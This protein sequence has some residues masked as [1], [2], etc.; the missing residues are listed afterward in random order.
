MS[1]GASPPASAAPVSADTPALS[2]EVPSTTAQEQPAT[3]G[4]SDGDAAVSGDEVAKEVAADEATAHDTDADKQTK[5]GDAPKEGSEPAAE[6]TDV[7]MKDAEKPEESVSVADADA[8]ADG[9]AEPAEGTPASA[10][11][12]KGRRKSVGVPEHKNKKLSKKASVAKITHIDAK[13][14]DYFLARLKG[15]PPWPCIICS[16]DMIPITLNKSRPMSAARADG[17]Y[18]PNYEDGAPKAKDR[19]FPIMYLA[20]NEFGWHVNTELTDV[21]LDTV[22]EMAVAKKKGLKEA[23]QIAAEQ[24][25]LDF[26][27]QMLIAHEESRQAEIAEKAAAK[28]AKKSAKTKRKSKVV[29]EEDE[30]EDT[31]MADAAA[32]EEPEAVVEPSAKKKTKKRKADEEPQTPGAPESNKKPKVSIKFT[33]KA[34]GNETA[35]PKSA[36]EKDTPAKATK[37]KQTKK[38]SK[39]K[40][41]VEAPKEP[42]MT[43]EERRAKKEKEILFLRH[44]LQKGLLTKEQDPKEDEMKAMSEFVTKLEGYSDLEVSIIR[45]TK[46]NKVLKAIL[47]LNSIPKEEEFQFKPRSQSLLDKWNKLLANEDVPAAATNGVGPEGKKAEDA[48]KE[49]ANGSKDSPAAEK[50]EEKSEEQADVKSEG[51]TD[52][53]AAE[54]TEE[55]PKEEIDE[56]LPAAETAEETEKQTEESTEVEVAPE[57]D[58]VAKEPKEASVESTT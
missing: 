56:T 54:E 51:K 16:E 47:K 21:D 43:P 40:E 44:K 24:H 22:G 7:E 14:G 55:K 19:S 42:E 30:D 2:S 12:P 10:K 6:Q 25:D 32:E 37:A 53:E 23:H 34:N 35:T 41:T 57:A 27:K 11:T 38:A 18:L 5:A 46:I 52:D 17:T 13:P 29:V 4:A 26:F 1:D 20:T 3:N 50:T 49:A 58:E 15:Y 8:T 28:E 45:A 48:S 36:K 9:S 39:V 33:A 31:E